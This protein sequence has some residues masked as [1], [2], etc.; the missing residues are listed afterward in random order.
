M[1]IKPT[2][3]DN[4]TKYT[5]Y[6]TDVIGTHLLISHIEHDKD[7]ENFGN[8]VLYSL[9]CKNILPIDNKLES[10]ELIDE[11]TN[12]ANKIVSEYME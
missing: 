6:N 5:R 7:K 12:I 2:N 3:K 10:I 11:L 4:L 1:K 9:M 8:L